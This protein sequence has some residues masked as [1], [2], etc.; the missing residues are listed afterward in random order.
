MQFGAGLIVVG[1]DEDRP[2]AQ[3]LGHHLGSVPVLDLSGQT[4]LLELAALAAESDLFLS[5]DTGPSSSG[6]RRREQE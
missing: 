4:T 2:L 3:A 5:N 1:S 6:R